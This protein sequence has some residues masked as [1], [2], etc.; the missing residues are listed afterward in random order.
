MRTT[1]ARELGAGSG[2]SGSVLPA[3]CS[4]LPALVALLALAGC[5]P[6]GPA[7]YPV[8]GTV[9]Y[10][11]AAVAD[12]SIVFMPLDKRQSAEADKISGGKFSFLAKEGKK[13][14][15]IRATCEVGE[16]VPSMGA[17]AKQSYIPVEYNAE[18]TLTA[19]VIAGGKNQFT[20]DL[21]GS[22]LETP[23]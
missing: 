6:P 16:V 19:E 5:K 12:G 14:V 20:F 23:K 1:K 3:P 18:T 7:T 2:D 4:L 21:K 11:G 22:P 8:S 17:R 10:N 15:E 9:T 13:K